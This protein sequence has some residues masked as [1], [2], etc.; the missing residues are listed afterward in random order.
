L[1]LSVVLRSFVFGVGP[2]DPATFVGIPALLVVTI[3][4]ACWA[5]AQ[6]AAA[7]EPTAALRAE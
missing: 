7:I 2:G 6:R 1:G 4:I 3:L 5:P